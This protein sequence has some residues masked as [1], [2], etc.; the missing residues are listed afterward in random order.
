ML[1]LRQRL[2]GNVKEDVTAPAG[3]RPAQTCPPLPTR[4]HELHRLSTHAV[5][6]QPQSVTDASL[7]AKI[8]QRKARSTHKNDVNERPP[9]TTPAQPTD[10]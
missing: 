3:I 6:R 10:S 9:C 4:R 7:D 5:H 1:L 2:K 8:M